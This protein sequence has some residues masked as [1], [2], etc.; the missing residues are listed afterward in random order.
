MKRNERRPVSLSSST[1]E[2]E[3]VGRHQ[4]GR[5]LDALVLE[6]Q[7]DAERFDEPRLGKAGNADEQRVTAGQERDEGLIDHLALAEDDAA[8]ALAHERQA[9]AERV[10]GGGEVGGRARRQAV[11]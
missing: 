8:D 1:S 11:A 2:P 4:V 7:H 3:N 6:P 5:A 9:L 10:D